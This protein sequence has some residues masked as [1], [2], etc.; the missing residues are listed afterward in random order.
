M[1]SEA[2]LVGAGIVVLGA[3]DVVPLLSDND[4]GKM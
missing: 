4:G 3:V 1:G 2:L